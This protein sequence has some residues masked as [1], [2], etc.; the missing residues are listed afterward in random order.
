[1]HMTYQARPTRQPA[2]RM[3]S[4]QVVRSLGSGGTANVWLIRYRH[5]GKTAALKQ[6][7][8][9]DKATLQLFHNEGRLLETLSHPHIVKLEARDTMPDG[10][11]FLALEYAPYGTIRRSYHGAHATM[12]LPTVIHFTKQIASAL[13]Y[14]HSRGIIHRDVK[15]ENML[16]LQ[17]DYLLLADFGIAIKAHLASTQQAH[18]MGTIRYMA[19]EQLLGTPC[20]A[21]DQYALAVAVYEWLS[22]EPPFL[23]TASEVI[24]QHL[25]SPPPPLRGLASLLP[26][27]L[28]AVVR[29]AL[30]KNPA[31]RFASVAELAQALEKSSKVTYTMRSHLLAIEDHYEEQATVPEPVTVLSNR[32]NKIYP[33]QKRFA[34]ALK[35]ILYD[36]LFLSVGQLVLWFFLAPLYSWFLLASSFTML[37]LLRLS[38]LRSA[39]VRSILSA[40]MLASLV[41]AHVLH[42]RLSI[43][44]HYALSLLL[45]FYM[46][47]TLKA[48][49]RARQQ[50]QTSV[51]FQKRYT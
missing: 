48:R 38:Q 43:D 12:P 27:R 8:V 7:R 20:F 22:G 19:P 42:S 14:L 36:L 1:M 31:D 16:L 41:V 4:Y 13:S 50:N 45:V 17:P 44:G 10:T 39:F 37:L 26:S 6:P 29:K 21:S 47:I 33:K 34:L 35:N 40:V 49:P 46:V 23:G 25:S 11:P 3:P 5:T 24:Q 51:Q 2:V 15:P 30:S 18:H 28:D 9:Q 32:Y